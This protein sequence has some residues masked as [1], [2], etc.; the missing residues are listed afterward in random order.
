MKGRRDAPRE[1][2]T[3]IGKGQGGGTAGKER[4]PRPSSDC[5]EDSEIRAPCLRIGPARFHGRRICETLVLEHCAPSPSK[6]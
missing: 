3:G 1:G 2:E 4:K 5:L 6:L